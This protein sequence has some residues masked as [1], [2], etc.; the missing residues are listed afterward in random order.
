MPPWKTRRYSA[1]SATSA[2]FLRQKAAS[3]YRPT[4]RYGKAR[5]PL[6]GAS[7]KALQLD[8]GTMFA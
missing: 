1:H 8:I 7:L 2:F 3:A 6:A 5:A 4:A